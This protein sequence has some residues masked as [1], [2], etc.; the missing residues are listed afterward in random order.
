M[1][2]I[3]KYQNFNESKSISDSCEVVTDAIWNSI[4]SNIISNISS[5]NNF[6]FD[7]IDFKLKD[8]V[9][10]Y[11]LIKSTENVCNAITFLKNSSV[12]N[13]YL[14]NINIVLNIRY[15]I[16]DEPFLYYI[17]SVLFHE[18]LH[19]FQHYN[20]KINNR[21]RSESFSIGSI[22]PQLR[23]YI[24]TKYANYILDVLY[25][26][27][28]HELSAQLHQYYMYKKIGKEYE[29]IDDI[30]NL[31]K[32]F[33]I[34]LDLDKSEE[35]E[36]NLIKEY[37]IKSI[38]FY[39]NNKKY[40][41]HILKSIWSETDNNKFLVKLSDIIKNKL[42]WIDKKIKLVDS[43]I[44]I[45]VDETFTFYGDLI[46]YKYSEAFNFIKENLNDCESYSYI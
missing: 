13:K 29:K 10:E 31:L 9:I 28:S 43:K 41:K 21:F 22:I 5:S 45:K 1:N 20:F 25:Y 44:E 26:S 33:H 14:S 2:Y 23:Q 18:M 8:I 17:K 24:N 36:I 42:I 11:N 16:L 4:E 37:I 40:N 34:K 3:L 19:V 15:H 27:L 7:E 35:L 39:S 30:R 38:S 46:D 32:N 12:D 6:D